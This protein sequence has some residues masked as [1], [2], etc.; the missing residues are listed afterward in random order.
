[1]KSLKFMLLETLSVTALHSVQGLNTCRTGVKTTYR[2]TTASR[3]ALALTP[4]WEIS[5]EI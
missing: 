1:M 5:R 2:R 4:V 3:P